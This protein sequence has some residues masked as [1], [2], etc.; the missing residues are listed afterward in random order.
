MVHNLTRLDYA[1]NVSLIIIKKGQGKVQ[2]GL[3]SDTYACYAYV[4]YACY[5][6]VSHD[7]ERVLQSPN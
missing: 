1:E 4:S 5:A 2:G 3:V 6:Y 7:Y